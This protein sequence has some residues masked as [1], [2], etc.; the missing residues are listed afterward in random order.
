MHTDKY[1]MYLKIGARAKL[2][3]DVRLPGKTSIEHFGNLSINIGAKANVYQ[4]D[5][6]EVNGI[7]SQKSFAKGKGNKDKKG[8]NFAEAK[9]NPGGIN[10]ER[11]VTTLL[12][13][14]LDYNKRDRSLVLEFETIRQAIDALN[15]LPFGI[16]YK[17]YLLDV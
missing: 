12:G 11:K 5:Y 2:P 4:R 10:I 16:N 14:T 9:F 6:S 8:G 1:R 7:I 13:E 15:V 17:L 3:E